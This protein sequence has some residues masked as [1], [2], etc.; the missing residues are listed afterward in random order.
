M[1]TGARW[2]TDGVGRWHTSAIPVADE[3]TVLTPDDM[4]AGDHP[5]SRPGTAPQR[6]LVFDDDHYYLGGVLAERLAKA[7]A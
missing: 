4:L 5:L 6:I 3:A 1:A 2:R 7:R